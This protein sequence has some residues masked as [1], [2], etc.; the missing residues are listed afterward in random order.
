M[1]FTKRLSLVFLIA[2]LGVCEIVAANSSY[3]LGLVDAARKSFKR[4][5]ARRATPGADSPVASSVSGEGDD[6]GALPFVPLKRACGEGVRGGGST[7]GSTV[8]TA[9]QGGVLPR[10]AG[11][12]PIFGGLV[13]VEAAP[14][15]VIAPK[16]KASVDSSSHR[17]RLSPQQQA[18]L[19]AG[20]EKF[21]ATTH[22][23]ALVV[24][25]EVLEEH[26]I[27]APAPVLVVA[28][29]PLGF[30]KASAVVEPG[31]PLADYNLAGNWILDKKGNYQISEVGCKVTELGKEKIATVFYNGEYGAYLSPDFIAAKEEL[32][33]KHVRIIGPGCLV[34]EATSDIS[35]VN[36][37][38][39][40]IALFKRFSSF[41]EGQAWVEQAI[42]DLGISLEKKPA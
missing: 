30:L 21:R 40:K 20:K 28:A 5:L 1:N 17:S 29:E 7:D 2:I 18:R 39:E 24:D 33:G 25:A 22:V 9:S 12:S 13:E 27:P 8:T 34:E 37:T 14:A 4:P 10:T 16:P 26:R 3:S 38:W 36:S 19:E 32:V 42:V 6:E 11:G 15:P 35:V 23:P 31:V 41:K